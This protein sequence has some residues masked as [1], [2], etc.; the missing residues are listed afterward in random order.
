MEDR[1]WKVAKERDRFESIIED[2]NIIISD[3]EIEK[4]N[5]ESQCSELWIE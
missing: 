5:F 2:K 4:S 1:E 3:L